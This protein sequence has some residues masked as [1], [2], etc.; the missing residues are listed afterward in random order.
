[1]IMIAVGVVAVGDGCQAGVARIA[2]A[3]VFVIALGGMV[4]VV[5]LGMAMADIESAAA[6][7]AGQHLGDDRR[8]DRHRPLPGRHERLITPS[9]KRHQRREPCRTA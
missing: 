4:V 2:G 6:L 5:G 1:M 8:D 9:K 3:A 7:Q